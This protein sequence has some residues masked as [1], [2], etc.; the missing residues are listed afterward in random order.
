M[1]PGC[2]VILNLRRGWSVLCSGNL[3]CV[4]G[5]GDLARLFI[6]EASAVSH[7]MRLLQFD[8]ESDDQLLAIITQ[9]GDIES[10]IANVCKSVLELVSL[11]HDVTFGQV[12]HCRAVITSITQT[13]L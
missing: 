1:Y 9:I 7:N 13:D 10:H 3:F 11:V 4:F 2:P 8:G 12:R 5:L 6:D